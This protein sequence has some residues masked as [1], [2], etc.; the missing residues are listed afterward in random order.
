[1]TDEV[2]RNE[3]T[4]EPNDITSDQDVTDAV[5]IDEDHVPDVREDEI[6]EP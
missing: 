3:P 1:M 5:P 6:T 2:D 4:P